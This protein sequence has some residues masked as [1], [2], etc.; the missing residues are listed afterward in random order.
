M[1]DMPV[2]VEALRVRRI[3]LG[4]LVHRTAQK[5]GARIA[6]VDGDVRL[7]YTELD[8]RSSRFAHYLL[9]HVGSGCQV[10]MLCQNSA[11]MMVAYNAIH[12]AGCV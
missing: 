1:I 11:D 6:V 8:A 5:Y 12:K 9:E 7:S 10:G 2:S 4:D 3:A